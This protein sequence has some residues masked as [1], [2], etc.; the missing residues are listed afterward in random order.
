M[1]YAKAELSNAVSRWRQAFAER[2]PEAL[3]VLFAE[4][5]WAL[6]PAS[7]P[8]VGRQAVRQMWADYFARPDLIHAITVDEVVEAE[9]GDLGYVFGRWWLRQPTA[10]LRQGGRYVAIWQPSDGA[11]EVTHLSANTLSDITAAEPEP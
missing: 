8:I 11:W 4:Q 9:Q 2:N 3:A 7:V 5:A 1:L 6:Y 10:G